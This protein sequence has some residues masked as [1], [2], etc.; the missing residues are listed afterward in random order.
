METHFHDV[1]VDDWLGLKDAAV[2][3]AGAGGIGS[4]IVAGFREVGARVVV[5]DANRDN[6]GPDG[7]VA[8]LTDPD[9]CRRVIADAHARLGRL[10]VLVHAVGINNRKP[11]VDLSDDEWRS[12]VDV[13]LNSAFWLGQAAGKIMIAQR[14]GRQVYFSSVS[15]VLGHKYHAPYAASKGGI[16]QM[17]RVM[18]HEWA[19]S[20]VSVNAVGPGYIETPLTAAYLEKPGIR[21]GLEALVP[22]GRLGV[23]DDVVGP[24]LFLASKHASFVTGQILYIDGGRTVV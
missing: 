6:A 5:A 22:A 12:I 14:Y 20:N 15:G 2:V 1:K 3:I 11:V 17:V 19:A 13:N 24:V 18:A 10:D 9:A 4:A 8:D 23:V 7:I 21:A 16:N